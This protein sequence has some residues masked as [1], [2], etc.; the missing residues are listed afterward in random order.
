MDQYD[1]FFKKE[2]PRIGMDSLYV[3]KKETTVGNQGDGL[4][5]AW[6]PDRFQLLQWKTQSLA[7]TMKHLPG[8]TPNISVFALFQDRRRPRHYIVFV[9]CH[10][11]WNWNFDHLRAIQAHFMF[12]KL[13]E[14][15]AA[16]K[17]QC[18]GSYETIVCGDFNSDPTSVAYQMITGKHLEAD[19]YHKV[20]EPSGLDEARLKAMPKLF[21]AP[22]SHYHSAYALQQIH[23]HKQFS[24]HAEI[25]WTNH[26]S[27]FKDTL[28]YI[29][30][31][32]TGRLVVRRL[33]MVPAAELAEAEGGLP[34]HYYSSDHVA[35]V[36]EFGYNGA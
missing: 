22:N 10:L 4:C 31:R 35:L 33:L 1:K 21:R 24:A 29:F 8:A 32:D 34:N 36:A 12:T 28:D 13:Q 18:P 26:V 5:I 20:M 3:R 25:S 6:R 16:C 14:W 17:T 11:Y 15:A 30:F 9:T 27:A 23:P 7:E 2:F 19:H